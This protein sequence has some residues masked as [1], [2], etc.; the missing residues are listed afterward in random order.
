MLL[1]LLNNRTAHHICQHADMLALV[2]VLML[3]DAQATLLRVLMILQ[4]Q[5]YVK[6]L[7][8]L[9]ENSVLSLLEP[10]VRK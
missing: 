1:L 7:Q 9:Q 2:L 6:L 8:I 3:L 10:Y 5:L 4:K